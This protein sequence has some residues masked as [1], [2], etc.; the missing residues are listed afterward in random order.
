M[1]QVESWSADGTGYI[2]LNRPAAINALT[3]EM[4]GAIADRLD[5]WACTDDVRTVELSG[6]GRGFCA[7]ADV[8]ALR[9]CVLEGAGAVEFLDAEYA[10]DHRIAT[11]P[12]PIVARL[13]GIV[14]GGGMGLSIHAARRVVTP[15]AT[16]AM[17]ETAIGL[18]PDVGMTYHL[19]RLAGELGTYMALTGEPISGALAVAVGLAD[20]LTAPT[21]PQ[22]PLAW[23]EAFAGD[24]PVAI[25]ARLETSPVAEARAAGAVIR[26]R[27]PLSVAVSLAAVRRA[28][29]LSLAGVFEQDRRLGRFFV[30]Q[31]DFVEGVRARLVDKDF[32]PR[33]SYARLE[34]V[35]PG[36]VEDAFQS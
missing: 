33:W 1:I 12:K 2:R 21:E 18:W 25:L 29:G 32:A 24:D 15:D 14:M 31:P 34:D 19:A 7:G 23:M 3:A 22:T 26:T 36:L 28:A 10:L 11:Y 30:S 35:P 6:A 9:Q 13:H 5:E 20:E 8:R 27:S 17:P 16:L 4:I